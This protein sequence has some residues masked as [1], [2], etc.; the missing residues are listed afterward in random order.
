MSTIVDEAPEIRPVSAV[1]MQA[2]MRVLIC[3]SF[4]AQMDAL[5]SEMILRPILVGQLPP[6]SSLIPIST[7]A[8]GWQKHEHFVLS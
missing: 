8:N 5:T 2:S 3:S 1:S 7:F 6:F 4:R